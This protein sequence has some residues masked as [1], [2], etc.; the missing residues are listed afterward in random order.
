MHKLTTII[1]LIFVCEIIITFI[2]K[3]YLH[4]RNAEEYINSLLIYGFFYGIMS[5][6]ILGIV[7]I[8][9]SDTYYLILFSLKFILLSVVSE[10]IGRTIFT[11]IGISSWYFIS[12]V[13][14][15]IRSLL[16]FYIL[17]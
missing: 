14:G 3:I 8:G 13:I 16:L 15:F 5:I 2:S 12:V 17:I 10:I 11:N 6:L 9:S 7:G 1:F 4:Y